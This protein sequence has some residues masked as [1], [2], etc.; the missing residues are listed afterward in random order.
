M[1]VRRLV[2]SGVAALSFLTVLVVAR[3]QESVPISEHPEYAVN[4][5]GRI[6]TRGL[7]A[8]WRGDGDA[9]DR[10]GRSSGSA[11]GGVSFVPAMVGR[12]FYF[13]GT[14]GGVTIPDTDALR[15]SRSLTLS[16]WIYVESFPT[17]EQGQA[18]ILFRGDDRGGLDPYHLAITPTRRLRFQIEQGYEQEADVT[19]P[20]GAGRFILVTATLDQMTRRMRL[21]Q[22]GQLTAE[23]TTPYTALRDL[24]SRANPGVGIGHHGGWPGSGFRYPFHGVI[25][26]VLVYDR[27]LSPAEVRA[28]YMDRTEVPT[29]A[30]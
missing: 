21:Y 26:E 10:V 12:G 19:A 29:L 27:A 9:R 1:G 4:A 20:T 6:S 7:V 30:P 3:A 28:L 18:L 16:A 23:T 25:N 15:L 24:D 13:N 5:A 22:N 8:A 2:F 14:D 11:H 17:P